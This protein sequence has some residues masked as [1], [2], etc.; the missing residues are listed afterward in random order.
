MAKIN[1][2]YNECRKYLPEEGKPIFLVTLEREGYK[3]HL[4]FYNG[5]IYLSVTG[6]VLFPMY[7]ANIN[8]KKIKFPKIPEH[9]NKFD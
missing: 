6:E 2:D 7:W 3:Y 1:Y 8:P 5:V 4:G 9:L